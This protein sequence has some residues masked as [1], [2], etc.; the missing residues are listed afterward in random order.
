MD[1]GSPLARLMVQEVGELFFIRPRGIVHF[2]KFGFAQWRAAGEALPAAIPEVDGG[3]LP[4]A[5]HDAGSIEARPWC[6]RRV[7]NRLEQGGILLG[8]PPFGV[9]EQAV[10]ADVQMTHHAVEGAHAEGRQPPLHVGH[11]ARRYA[12]A[13]RKLAHTDPRR[14]ASDPDSLTDDGPFG[15]GVVRRWNFRNHSCLLSARI[16]GPSRA[17]F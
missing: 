14:L 6:R 7:G 2:E 12:D 16:L 8:G 10:H 17:S 15:L 5:Q 1:D 3:S 11:V 13:P 4:P 9:L